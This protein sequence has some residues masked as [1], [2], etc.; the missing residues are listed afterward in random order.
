LYPGDMRDFTHPSRL[1][2]GPTQPPIQG[3]LGSLLGAQRPRSGVDHS[4]PYSAEVKE[5]VELYIYS[6][7]ELSWLALGQT[8]PLFTLRIPN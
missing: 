5:R 6:P 8:L 2:L 1:A 7:S 3:V 4:P